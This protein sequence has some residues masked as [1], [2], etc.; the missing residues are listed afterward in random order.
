MNWKVTLEDFKKSSYFPRF[1]GWAFLSL[2]IVLCLVYNYP[3]ILSLSPQ[4]VHQWR[5]CDCLSITLNYYQDH[6]S[7]FQPS[8]H[9]LGRDGTGK[10]V[11]DFP[12]IYFFVA[13]L[14]KIFGQHEFIFRLLNLILFFFGMF[15]LFRLFEL[16]LKD[17]VLALI[18]PFFLFTSPVITYYANNF[19]MNVPALSLGMIGLYFFFRFLGTSESRHFILFC[20]F[21]SLAGLL[22]ISSLLSFCGICA[23]FLLEVI[24][25]QIRPDRKI[26]SRPFTQGVL[27]A[28]VFIIQ[29]IWYSFAAYYNNRYNSGIFLVGTLP[30][31][32]LNSGQVRE[33]IQAVR[34]HIDWDYFRRETQIL[35]VCMFV[36]VLCYYKQ[37][38][39]TL[40]VILVVMTFGMA[41]YLI[42]FFQALKDHDYYTTD[43]FILVPVILL[44]FLSVLQTKFP[45]VYNSL[46][47]RFVAIIFLIHNIDFDRMR[48]E[49]RYGSEGW[50]NR[51]YLDHL[52]H[53]ETIGPYLRGLG[54][55]KEDPVL[56]LSDNSINISLYLMNQKGWT[57]Y[58]IGMDSSLIR[59]K[60]RMGARYLFLYDEESK[61]NKSLQPF[62][63]RPI[64][65]YK[66]IEI[67]KL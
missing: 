42:L 3:H 56:S 7:F 11:S 62:L 17:S 14:W 50:E 29:L 45:G 38:S 59:E 9:Y 22:K 8:V 25:I 27:L 10:T 48:M 51:I 33:V 61:M 12:L 52:Q 13:Q 63:H 43:L 19:L 20:L 64:G 37:M 32:E 58:G 1:S 60:I 44:A 67:Y 39:R 54:I 31:W 6:T 65:T 24:S 55:K 26:F 15:A 30:L 28:A 47:F 21:Y 41:S 18:F 46:L 66:T 2:F 35:L 23:L 36:L 40:F 57:N 53:F 5:Q 16:W 34:H 49:G 4:S